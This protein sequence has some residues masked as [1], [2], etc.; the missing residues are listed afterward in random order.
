[1]KLG[2]YSCDAGNP[3]NPTL[4][5]SGRLGLFVRWVGVT[6]APKGDPT[7]KELQFFEYHGDLTAGENREVVL[8]FGV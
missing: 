3:P 5:L 8:P 4:Y 1:M 7:L 2:I 6:D